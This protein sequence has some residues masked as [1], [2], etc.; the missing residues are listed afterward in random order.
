MSAEHRSSPRLVAGLVRTALGL[1]WAGLFV[2]THLPNPP[3]VVPRDVSDTWLHFLAYLGL[4]TLLVPAISLPGSISRWTGLVAWGVAAVYATIDEL[5]QMIPVLHRTAE[6]KDWF[7]DL[8]GAGCGVLIG[9]LIARTWLSSR[10]REAEGPSVDALHR[11]SP[12]TL[13]DG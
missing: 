3:V 5:L 2:A 11:R 10:G 7:A 12:D 9:A 6:W 8:G 1:Y 4:A 13:E